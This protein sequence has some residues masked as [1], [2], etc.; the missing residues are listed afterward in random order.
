[1]D[2]TP[3]QQPFSINR[4]PHWHCPT[5]QVGMLT[6]DTKSL[7]KQ[8]TAT[9]RIDRFHDEWDPEWIRY[10]FACVFRC[11]NPNCTEVVACT[12][13]GSVQYFHYPDEEPDLGNF[14]GEFFYPRYFHPPLVLM[15]LPKNCPEKVAKYLYES[16]A[17]SFADP[18]AALNCARTAV[19]ALMTALGIP[20][21]AEGKG[22]M[23]SMSLHER[24]QALPNN[25]TE[26]KNLLLAVKWLGNAG[27]HDGDKPTTEHLMHTYDLLE[28]ALSEIYEAKVKKLHALAEMV[29]KKKGPLNK[30]D[31]CGT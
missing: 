9:S 14:A 23:R 16:F 24:I 5:C 30:G 12:G 6:L 22:K 18:S 27:S 4:V 25:H 26:V 7:N 1:M 20:L 21:F 13:S 8:E 10:V 3:Y 2:R 29:N 31:F 19:E 15:D 28:H 11:N 17:L